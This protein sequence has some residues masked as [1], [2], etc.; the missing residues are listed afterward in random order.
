MPG[1]GTR[2][3]AAAMGGRLQWVVP[4][5]GLPWAAHRHPPLPG[6]GYALRVFSITASTF[7]TIAGLVCPFQRE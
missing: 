2:R 1:K 5:G 4:V 6:G 7:V 3:R